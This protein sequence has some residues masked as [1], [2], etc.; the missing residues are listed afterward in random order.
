MAASRLGRFRRKNHPPCFSSTDRRSGRLVRPTLEVL[1]GRVVLNASGLNPAFGTNGVVLSPATTSSGDVGTAAYTS[2]SY[3]PLASTVQGDGKIVTV[4]QQEKIANY[5]ASYTLIVQ[6]VNVDGTVDTGFGTGGQATLPLGMLTDLTRNVALAV[7]SDGSIAVAGQSGT[8]SSSG[9]TAI[10]EFAARLTGSGALVTG[11]GTSGVYTQAAS[12]SATGATAAV[13]G[14]GKVL[15]SSI[16][17]VNTSGAAGYYQASVTRLTTAGAPDTSFAGT[18]TLTFTLPNLKP[19]GA[20]QYPSLQTLTVAPDGSIDL[21]NNWDSYSGTPRGPELTRITSAG[22]VDTSFGTGGTFVLPMDILDVLAFQADG[23]VVV[24]GSAFNDTFGTASKL[25][26]LNADGSTDATFTGVTGTETTGILTRFGGITALDIAK[27]GDVL[28][29]DGLAVARLLPTGQVDLSFGLNGLIP[30]TAGRVNS[31]ASERFQTQTIASLATTSTGNVVVTGN[32]AGGQG[33]IGEMLPARIRAVGT[34][35]DGDGK[36]DIAV[37]LADLAIAA[38]RPSAGGADVLQQFGRAGVGE[39]IP[40]P[41][42]YDGDGITDV[43]IDMPALGEFAYRPSAGGADVLIQLGKV[44]TGAEIPVSGDFDGDGVSDLALYEPATGSFLIDLTGRTGGVLRNYGSNG[45]P[46]VTVPFGLPGVGMTIP[47]P[48][49]YD[50]DGKTDIAAYLPS[51]AI[52]AYRPSTGGADVLTSFGAVGVSA[53]IPTPG[54][55]DGD[56]RTDLSVYLPGQA[57]YAYRPSS[58]GPDVLTSFGAIGIG[59]SIPTP[60]DYTGDGRADLAVF[61]PQYAQFAYRPTGGGADA[62]ALFGT[63]GTSRT[64]PTAS[65]PYAQQNIPM[66]S[67]GASGGAANASA[68]MALTVDLGDPASL[69]TTKKKTGQLS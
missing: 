50:G 46:Y 16:R 1:E 49:D 58:G 33:G 39:S 18:G 41:G 19:S 47:A 43:A 15:L 11:Y 31:T 27:N 68:V 5:Q 2:T 45:T 24:G 61:L 17:Y 37:Q 21:G 9:A 28:I 63:T 14:D 4:V 60:G 64:V 7:N 62:N 25:V 67:N 6:R 30:F 32:V 13:Q 36:S 38:Y 53:S 55:Y 26:R 57:V 59:G 40:D 12:M 29:G 44:G 22:A 51:Q 42:D 3:L 54:D 66:S 23:K 52:Y 8:A 20:V 34:D 65:L 48:G 56:G 35:Y 69:T 10:Q